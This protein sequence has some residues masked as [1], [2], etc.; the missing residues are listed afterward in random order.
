MF[1]IEPSSLLMPQGHDIPLNDLFMII[2]NDSNE[3]FM[4]EQ[5][6]RVQGCDLNV[7]IREMR[8]QDQTFVVMI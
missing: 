4:C 2:L 8:M 5:H 7:V 1:C 3:S 6:F